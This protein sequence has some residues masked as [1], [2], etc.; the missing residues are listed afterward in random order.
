GVDLVA[1]TGISASIAQTIISEIGTDMR[2][3]PTVKHFCSWLGL[4]PHH[5]ISGGRVLCPAALEKTVDEKDAHR[6]RQWQFSRPCGCLQI[7]R[8][9]RGMPTTC[10]IPQ[11]LSPGS[12]PSAAA[13]S[14]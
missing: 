11:W 3:F 9:N 10:D 2:K 7:R 12:V 8:E 14:P 6:C 5:D 4:P 1:V 13:N